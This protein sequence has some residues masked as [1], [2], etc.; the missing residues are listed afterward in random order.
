MNNS[1]SYVYV[2]TLIDKRNSVLTSIFWHVLF[3]VRSI[4]NIKNGYNEGA[5]KMLYYTAESASR[6]DEANPAFLLATRALEISH[7][8]PTCKSS[9]FGDILY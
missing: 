7:V 3:F 6:Q 1:N 2:A 9:L 8:R 4:A 5:Y